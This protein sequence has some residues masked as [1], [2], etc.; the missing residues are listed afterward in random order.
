MFLLTLSPLCSQGVRGSNSGG[1]LQGGC[2]EH[3][4]RRPGR[5]PLHLHLRGRRQAQGA[6][7]ENHLHPRHTAVQ[8]H[9]HLAGGA[10]GV[11]VRMGRMLCS[12]YIMRNVNLQQEDPHQTHPYMITQ[13]VS[14]RISAI[15][16]AVSFLQAVTQINSNNTTWNILP[17]ESWH[18]YRL[19]P[20]AG[21]FTCSQAR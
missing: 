4:P 19:N 16:K 7:Q 8:P 12:V 2:G 10:R 20:V 17:G 3:H 15:R 5:P 6:E 18:S 21:A 9:V 14:L 13:P 1:P 11:H